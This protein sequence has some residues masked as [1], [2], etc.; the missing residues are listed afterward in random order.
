[1]RARRRPQRRVRDA[2]A[3]LE[4]LEVVRADAARAE[5]QRAAAE[6]A[7][8]PHARGAV[9]VV[10]HD[11][12]REHARGAGR[13]RQVGPH[14]DAR[15]VDAVDALQVDLA[16][17]A[18]VVPPAPRGVAGAGQAG[19]RE[20]GPQAAVV[21]A[22]DEPVGALALEHAARQ[23]HVPR[24]VRARV[25]ADRPAVEP[26]L[27]AVVDRLEAH[28]PVHPRAPVGE[29]EVLAIPGD[30]AGHRRDG[31]VAGVPGVGNAHRLPAVGRGLV[32]EALL[33]ALARVE[34]EQPVAAEQVAVVGSVLVD[35]AVR[36]AV[37]RERGRSARQG[38]E[39]GERGCEQAAHASSGHNTAY[40]RELCFPARQ[41][42]QLA[43]R[44]IGAVTRRRLTVVPA[45]TLPLRRT[46]THC[47]VVSRPGVNH[48]TRV[49]LVLEETACAVP[50]T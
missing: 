7:G 25:A 17:Q 12:A 18:A 23:A 38:G 26:D 1:M 28:E 5:V 24:Q 2:Q 45:N 15:D 50:D 27:R 14:D 42:G 8:D 9:A 33:G 4:A 37:G 32:L 35:R 29:V 34:P 6:A 30:G 48:T 36:D 41:D 13:A 3:G 49:N 22:H 20:V 21:D 39:Q 31:V 11:D 46:S 44:P 16:Q 43:S 40:R 47:T 19:G 10:A